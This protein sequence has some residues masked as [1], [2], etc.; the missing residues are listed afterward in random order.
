MPDENAVVVL[1]GGQDSTTCLYWAL[2]RYAAVQAVTFHYGQRH[3]IEIDCAE[4]IANIAQIDHTVV[5]L[6]LFT[7][8]GAR[9]GMLR[10]DEPISETGSHTNPDLPTTFVPGRNILMLSA[11][12]SY[13]HNNN[14][15]TIVTGVS[16]VD[17]SG[18]P[19]CRMP[20]IEALQ[21]AL[22]LGLD[23]P[24]FTIE[25][26]LIDTDKAGIWQLADNLGIVD[27]VIEFSHTC[28]TG[29]RSERND[30]GYGCGECPACKLR[31]AG[32]ESWMNQQ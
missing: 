31:A 4:Q 13:A 30:W 16:Q 17:Y 8:I 29:D 10:S 24:Q 2:D 3:G 5:H 27:T 21:T 28:Y 7:Q 15:D 11:A 1:S 20:T 18:Y 23:S 9:S 12:A 19:D 6:D 26:P 25:T 32:Y 22:A 14:C